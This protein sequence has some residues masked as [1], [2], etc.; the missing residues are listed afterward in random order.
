MVHF[1]EIS[2]HEQSVRVYLWDLERQERPCVWKLGRVRDRG[3]RL[4]PS[5]DLFRFHL[6]FSL[7]QASDQCL[8]ESPTHGRY[9]PNA[10]YT[11]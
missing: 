5:L 7:R 8:W 4:T 1:V 11:V 6:W 3:F 2:E 9:G 10:N